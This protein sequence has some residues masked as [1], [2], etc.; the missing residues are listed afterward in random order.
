ML[1]PRGLQEG[2]QKTQAP[3]PRCQRL[4]W[5]WGESPRAQQRFA[6][7]GRSPGRGAPHQGLG[8]APRD[9][10]HRSRQRPPA[11]LWVSYLEKNGNHGRGEQ[12]SAQRNAEWWGCGQGTMASSSTT[13]ESNRVGSK[14]RRSQRPS[15][16]SFWGLRRN[17]GKGQLS[18]TV[19]NFGSLQVVLTWHIPWVSRGVA[20]GG[21][22]RPEYICQLQ[23]RGLQTE[24]E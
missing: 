10:L 22:R 11:P 24:R 14:G 19:P 13:W 15:L 1:F 20:G 4:Q 6:G 5:C 12:C 2:S 16:L 9:P 7:M 18:A 8:L 17:R 23:N 3:S 21:W